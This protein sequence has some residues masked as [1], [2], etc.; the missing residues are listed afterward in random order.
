MTTFDQ[1]DVV[2]V[3]FPFTDLTSAKRRPALIVSTTWFNDRPVQDCILV[4][5]TSVVPDKEL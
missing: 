1:G 5:I 2:L 3:N 4:A